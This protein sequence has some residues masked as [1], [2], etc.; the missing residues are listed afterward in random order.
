VKQAVIVSHEKTESK[1]KMLRIHLGKDDQWEGKP[2]YEAIVLKLREMDIAGAT[3]YKGT[4]GFGAHQRLHKSGLPGL[5]RDLPI[6]ITVVD[7]EE[8][9]RGVLSVLDEMVHEGML[10][11][12]DVEVIKY[13][14]TDPDGPEFSLSPERPALP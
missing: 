5:S 10:S 11:I 12:S 9:I 4:M 2:L 13:A 3:V 6:M 14:H 7:K 8:K 1:A